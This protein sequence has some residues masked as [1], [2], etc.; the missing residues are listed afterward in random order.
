[1]ARKDRYLDHL[2]SVPLLAGCT[3]AQLKEVASIVTDLML[4]AGTV[5]MSEGATGHDFVIIL[6]GT[7]LVKRGGRKLNTLG[8]G[9]MVGELSLLTH[10]P[11]N[12]TVVAQTDLEVLVIA[13]REF[14]QLLDDVPGLA[15]K[16]L[17]AVAERLADATKAAEAAS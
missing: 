10:R 4:P 12:A 16:L 7:A 8:A 1:M 5:L 2:A 13:E 17:V 3:K 15:R 14:A 11:R 6:N 9:D